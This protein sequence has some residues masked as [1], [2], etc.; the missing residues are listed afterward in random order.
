MHVEITKEIFIALR[1]ALNLEHFA[2]SSPMPEFGFTDR[3]EHFKGPKDLFVD[4]VYD[5]ERVKYW[6]FVKPTTEESESE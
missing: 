3:K 2:F 1:A 5:K 6:L 4:V